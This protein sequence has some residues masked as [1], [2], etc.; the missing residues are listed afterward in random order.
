MT[1]YLD[2]TFYSASSTGHDAQGRT[3]EYKTGEV[4][5]AIE[6]PDGALAADQAKLVEDACDKTYDHL[7]DA[8]TKWS[9]LKDHYDAADTDKVIRAMDPVLEKL[10]ALKR[11]GRQFHSAVSTYNESISSVSTTRTSYNSWVEE[12]YP[13]WIAHLESDLDADEYEEKYGT[14]AMTRQAALMKARKDHEATG[15][16]KIITTLNGARAALSE[17][18]KAVDMA[19]LGEIRVSSTPEAIST[20][21]SVD[22]LEERI[23]NS[24]VFSDVKG[25]DG[26]AD[27]IAGSVWNNAYQDLPTDYI[28]THGTRWVFGPDGEAVRVGSAM[29]PNLNAAIWDA[30]GE[31][32]VVGKAAVD[33]PGTSFGTSGWGGTGTTAAELGAGEGTV[34]G[35]D[36][37][38]NGIDTGTDPVS[39][40]ASKNLGKGVAGVPIDVFATGLDINQQKYAQGVQSPLL[41]GDEAGGRTSLYAKKQFVSTVAGIA[42]A[43]TAIFATGATGGVGFVVGAGAGAGAS[44]AT[45]STL[46]GLASETWTVEELDQKYQSGEIKK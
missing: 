32:P 8:V 34:A 20:I 19:E 36:R 15:S 14:D 29:D 42:G 1:R 3:S 46:D 33:V 21:P 28:D 12:W 39:G 17:T 30:M 7:M 44:S 4:G 43:S 27:E 41:S 16:T 18:L 6:E 25:M 5:Y 23:K 11:A 10:V 31:D 35:Y 37:L 13:K 38:V 22:A 45:Q 2:I 9:T 24:H 26:R 40:T